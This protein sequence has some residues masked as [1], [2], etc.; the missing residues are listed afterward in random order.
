MGAAPD[1]DIPTSRSWSD[2]AVAR[3]CDR[4]IGLFLFSKAELWPTDSASNGPALTMKY[5]REKKN[6]QENKRSDIYNSL[7][8]S[9]APSL[10]NELTLKEPDTL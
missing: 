1:R 6:K 4:P 2:A 8:G 5:I 10:V 9:I 7:Q 3:R